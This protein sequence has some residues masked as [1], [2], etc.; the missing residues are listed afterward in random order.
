MC[1]FCAHKAKHMTLVIISL[2][3]ALIFIISTI[4][5]RILYFAADVEASITQLVISIASTVISIA[6]AII[7]I[8]TSTPSAF[9]SAMSLLGIG[10][11]ILFALA[12]INMI[13]HDY[14][15]PH[16]A[17]TW[18]HI[19]LVIA[20]E[21]IGIIN[22]LHFGMSSDY[23][24]LFIVPIGVAFVLFVFAMPIVA[25]SDGGGAGYRYEYSIGRRRPRL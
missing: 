4:T 11:C 6:C 17:Q 20:Y 16:T 1:A 3:A 2:I 12:P 25:I 14:F 24:S 10:N 23:S 21:T 9:L 5:F 19:A 18:C 7:G 22:V 15:Y 13:F 8:I